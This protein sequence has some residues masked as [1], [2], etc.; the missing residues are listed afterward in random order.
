MLIGPEIRGDCQRYRGRS[1]E[2]NLF[3]V[4]RFRINNPQIETWRSNFKD[5]SYFDEASNLEV[6]NAVEWDFG[7]GHQL[8]TSLSANSRGFIRSYR[9]GLI[10]RSEPFPRFPFNDGVSFGFLTLLVCNQCDFDVGH[11][12][13]LIYPQGV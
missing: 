1:R 3:D 13:F 9:Y 5:I 12:S 4:Y 6:F 2:L 7:L 11:S 8:S 10:I